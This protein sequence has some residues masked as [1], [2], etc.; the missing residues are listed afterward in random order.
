MNH[1][2]KDALDLEI[3]EVLASIAA[4]E[5][6][7]VSAASVRR[8]IGGRRVASLPAWLAAA[9]ILIVA[10]GVAV[11]S[12]TPAEKAPPE[13]IAQS[14]A[15]PVAPEARPDP[16][17]EPEPAVPTNE[18][19]PLRRP[20]RRTVTAVEQ[21]YEGLPRLVV[22]AIDAPEPLS[23]DLL[24]GESL[25]IPQIEISPLVVSSLPNEQEPK[26]ES[27]R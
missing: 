6:R 10:I 14:G 19:R 18:T 22:A 3:D 2:P 1:Q 24:S 15:A 25:V 4:E 8:A 11:K 20:S 16:S 13:V 21:P 5:P 26:Q 23:T 12:R 7:R 17:I 27:Q 9:A